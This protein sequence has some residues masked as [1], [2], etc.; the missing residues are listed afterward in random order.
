MSNGDKLIGAAGA[1]PPTAHQAYETDAALA[2]R[3]QQDA[4]PLMDQLFSGALRLARDRDD[5]EDL[6][7][8]TMLRAYIGF[9]SFRAGTNLKAWLYR[10]LH[11]TWISAYRNRQRRPVVVAVDY[12]TE[13]QSARYAGSAANGLRSAEVEVLEALP[14]VEIQAALLSL[15]EEF[16]IAIYYADVEGFSYAQIAE[17]MG[18]RIGTV[19]SRLHRGRT[20]LRKSLSTLA[21]QRRVLH[22]TPWR[23]RE[24]ISG[25]FHQKSTPP[26]C[27]PVPARGRCW[28]PRP[29]GRGWPPN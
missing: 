8:E 11:N 20:Q 26:E 19:T 22:P 23:T 2:E 14:D 16:R 25:R 29:A 27:I 15:R 12:I 18:T 7:Q 1:D 10:I 21:T 9:P 3:F 28:P 6:V 5:A 13:A 4:V 17:I 24:W